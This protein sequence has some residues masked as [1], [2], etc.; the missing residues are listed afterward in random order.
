MKT[1]DLILALKR[2][3]PSGELDVVVNNSP[4]GEVYRENADYNGWY[5]SFEGDTIKCLGTGH[6]LVLSVTN[7]AYVFNT[8]RQVK[9]EIHGDPDQADMYYHVIKNWCQDNE[10]N[11]VVN[12]NGT[13]DPD[14]DDP[15]ED[16]IDPD[17]DDDEYEVPEEPLPDR[18]NPPVVAELRA[19]EPQINFNGWQ[20]MVY[21][22][23]RDNPRNNR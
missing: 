22:E 9:A 23:F 6:K 11:I 15:D 4:I 12:P 14:E 13:E 5:Y 16:E 8:A 3:D 19:P 7:V 21:D 17:E 1:K 18:Y 10:V 20:A 2:E